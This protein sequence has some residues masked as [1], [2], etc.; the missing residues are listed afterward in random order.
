MLIKKKEEQIVY[1]RL[2]INL[3][4]HH[5]SFCYIMYIQTDEDDDDKSLYLYKCPSL[6]ANIFKFYLLLPI[7]EMV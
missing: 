2:P 5:E 7:F 3:D 6:L 4:I 1:N